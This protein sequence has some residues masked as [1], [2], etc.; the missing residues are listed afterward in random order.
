MRGPWVVR[1]GCLGRKPQS[2]DRVSNATDS[3]GSHLIGSLKKTAEDR[4]MIQPPNVLFILCDDLNDAIEGWGG[5]P[6][7]KTPN[8]KRLMSRGASF[9]NGHCNASICGPSRASLWSGLYPHTS[10]NYAFGDWRENRVLRDTT[11]LPRHFRNH[12]YQVYGTGKLQ[13]NGQEDKSCY[14]DFGY[15]AH[16]GPFPFDGIRPND[17]DY[18]HPN[19]SELLDGDPDIRIPWEQT[20]GPLSKIPHWPDDVATGPDAGWT[21]YNKPFRYVSDTDRDLMPDELSVEW[22]IEKLRALSTEKPFFMGVGFNRPHTPLYVPDEYFDRFPLEDIE[23]PPSLADDWDDAPEIAR[24]QNT[25]GLCRFNLVRQAGP[26]MWKQWIQAYL[27]SVSFVDD[28][29]GELLDYLESSP[30]ADNTIIVFT[31]DNGYHMG[32]KDILFKN[33]LYEEA[34]RIPLILSAPGIAQ[35]GTVCRAPVSLVDLYPTLVDLCRLPASPNA[36]GTGVALDGHSL[37]PLLADP[38]HGSFAGPAS[39]LTAVPTTRE[40]LARWGPHVGPAHFS[41]RGKRWRYSR[42]GNGEEELFDHDNDPLEYKNLIGSK[43]LEK[44]RTSEQAVLL[45]TLPPW[46]SQAEKP[47]WTTMDWIP[48]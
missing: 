18:E 1:A 43:E 34:T 16:F 45:A 10:E 21:C 41:R 40:T 22:A 13:H 3:N 47:D 32:E 42:Y 33:S 44:L 46:A 20:F 19:M 25:Y 29:V 35:P 39:V 9:L 30:H 38:E 36:E 7:T 8:L 2:A 11:M 5:H 12:G 28:Q 31:S 48:L 14:D 17:M 6:Q 37:R 23:L 26:G 27:A 24:D 15:D 4:L